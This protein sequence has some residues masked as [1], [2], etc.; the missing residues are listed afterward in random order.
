VKSALEGQKTRKTKQTLLSQVKVLGKK[1]RKARFSGGR[2]GSPTWK[3]RGT[4]P[5][6]GTD[7]G[8][9]SRGAQ[10]EK[11][12]EFLSGGGTSER[13]PVNCQVGGEENHKKRARK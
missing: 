3:K 8:R 13:V 4:K 10:A 7:K 11:G 9:R 5:G 6:F 2:A 1:R 12:R